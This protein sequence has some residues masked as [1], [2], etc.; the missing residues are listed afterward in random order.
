METLYFIVLISFLGPIIGSLIGV[1]KK[2]SKRFMYNLLAFA[3][4]IMLAISLMDL[5]PEGIEFSGVLVCAVGVGVGALVMYFLDRLIPH[6]H[7]ELC[8]PENGRELEKVALFIIIGIFLHNLPEGMAIAAGYV[9][10]EGMAGIT[11]AIAI[12]I[13]NIPEGVATAAPY[14][15]AT[16]KRLKAFLLS[17]STALPVV[18]GFL[19]AQFL[20]AEI[21]E[22]FLG[23]LFGVTAGIMIYICADELIP[24]SFNKGHSTIFSLIAGIIVFILLGLL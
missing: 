5:I 6:I 11:I 8:R 3:A 2:P 13:H 4:G 10:G 7:P 20:F 15:Q 23:L 9:S 24:A 19:I 1:I 12:A 21:P 18:I 17:A 16:G 22:L 14:Y